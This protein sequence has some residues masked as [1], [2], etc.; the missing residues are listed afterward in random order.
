M[1]ERPFGPLPLLAG[2]LV[3]GA[4]VIALDA[5]LIEPESVEL[6]RHDLLLPDL[7][8]EWISATLVHLTDLHFGDPRSHRLLRRMVETVNDL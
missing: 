1:P 6:T 2:L 8:E 5:F 4:A 7:P 3:A